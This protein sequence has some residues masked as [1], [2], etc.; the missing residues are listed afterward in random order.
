MLLAGTETTSTA[1]TWALL[2]LIRYP[3]IQLKVQTELDKVIGRNRL[4]NLE[5]R[6]RLPYTESVI[7]ELLRYCSVAPLGLPHMAGGDVVTS[8]G[9]YKIPKGTGESRE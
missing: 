4:P 3:D 8:D 2:L 9:K 1:L 7:Q 5:D 6:S